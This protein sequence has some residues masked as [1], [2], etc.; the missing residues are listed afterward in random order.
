MN[1]LIQFYKVL[2]NSNESICRAKT[3][4]GTD[5]YQSPWSIP[6]DYSFFSINPLVDKR[7]DANV[8]CYRNILLEFDSIPLKEQWEIIKNIPVSTIVYSGNKSYHAIISLEEPCT[9]R[10]S[11]DTLVN[12]IYAKVPQADRSARN[13]SRLSRSPSV[14]R[15]NGKKQYLMAVEARVSNKVMNMWLGTDIASIISKA[16]SMPSAPHMTRV[17]SPNTNWTLA[18][19]APEGS[20]NVK[21]FN[22]ACDM[23]RAGYADEEAFELLASALDL[24][25]RELF[26]AV[27]SAYKKVGI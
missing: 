4:K 10:R 5:I 2:F 18:N 3:V 25:Q 16:T 24:S 19:G 20:R 9:S 27:R 14:T 8:T 1:K 17:L 22:A 15:S 12:L 7:A 13:P 21:A 26:A 11:Y 23:A 6:G